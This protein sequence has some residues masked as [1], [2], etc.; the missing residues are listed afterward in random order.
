MAD[1][2]ASDA[3][4]IASSLTNPETFGVIYDRHF[5]AVF[6]YLGRAVSRDTALELAAEVFVR[7]F[8]TRNRFRSEYTSARPWLMGIAANLLAGHFR[9]RA[10]ERRAFARAVVRLDHIEDDMENEAVNRLH[11]EAYRETLIAAMASLRHEERSVVS[12]FA[13]GG[14][15]YAEIAHALSIPEGTVRSRLSRARRKLEALL[16]DAQLAGLGHEDS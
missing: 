4:V 5:R 15:S 12:L 13:V 7:A 16:K 1:V 8:G 9:G 10:R 11:A 14:L 6:G 3:E 2:P